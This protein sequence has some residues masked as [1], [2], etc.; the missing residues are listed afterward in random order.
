V[1]IVR[2]PANAGSLRQPGVR[3]I[4]GDLGSEAAIREAMAGADAIIRCAGVYH[5][6]IPASERPAM[7]EANVGTTQR[8]L[9]ASIALGIGQIVYVS[10]ANVL[11]TYWGT[12]A[13][14]A[15]ELGYA[16]RA[17]ETGAL[18]AFSGR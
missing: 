1:A 6:G 14:P 5:V 18:D 15:S 10:T 2:D 12:S 9:D 17:L 7:Y 16:P 8:V 3:P 4:E 11:G 13:K